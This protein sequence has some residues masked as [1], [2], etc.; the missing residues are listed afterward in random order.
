M[1]PQRVFSELKVIDFGTTVVG[2][3]SA[4]V[5][6][7]FGA[8][9]IKVETN[10]HVDGLR[11]SPPY[12][13]GI[14]GMNRSGYFNNYN[15]GKFSVSLNL[16]LPKAI[17]IAK[18]LVKWADVVVESFRPGVMEKWGLTYEALRALKPDLIMVSTNMLGQSGPHCQFRGYGHHGGAIAGWGSTIGWPDRAPLI[19]FGAYTD[20]LSARYVAVAILGALEYRRRTGKGQYIENS[21]VECS[22][23]FQGPWI[24]DYRINRKSNQRQG[25]Q[26]ADAAP[27]GAYRCKGEDRWCAIAV[28]TDEEWK[29]FCRVMGDPP[30]SKESK[31]STHLGRKGNEDQLDRLVEEWTVQYSAEEVEEKMQRGG[32]SAK[33]VKNWAD[34][35]QDPQ[36][37]HRGHFQEMNHTEIGP[38]TY[39]TFGFHLSKTPGG[40]QKAAPCLGEHNELVCTQILRLSHQEFAQ[41]I[42]EGIF[43]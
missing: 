9:V 39:E 30:W 4:R 27:H 20:Y 13:D 8:T 18:K 11:N 1:E 5:L 17:E 28:A 32:V 19:P 41:L 38:H 12:K 40:P 16:K 36:L 6:A 35:R 7:D 23:D 33:V 37:G 31:F 2:P 24:L 29:L 42:A 14:V 15:A 3:S 22:I 26:N 10:T 43:E 21:Q 34:M 25:N